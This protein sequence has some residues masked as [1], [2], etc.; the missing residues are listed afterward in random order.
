MQL[1][2]RSDSHSRID[3]KR[4]AAWSGVF[5]L[6]VGV[7]AMMLL[8]RES[9]LTRP[10][11][12]PVEVPIFDLTDPP[13]LPL[14]PP[15]IEIPPPPINLQRMITPPTVAPLPA[16]QPITTTMERVSSEPDEWPPLTPSTVESGSGADPVAGTGLLLTLKRISGRDPAY[17]R[18]ELARGIEGE[19]LLRV[20]VNPA[21]A[22]QTIEVIGGSGNRHLEL[23]AIRAVKGWRFQP[24][25]VNGAPQ[26]AWAQ[27]P[28]VFHLD[29]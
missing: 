12:L 5:L 9:T 17:P 29:R 10:R 1:T 11:M 19:V 14:P 4:V 23:A 8:P 25:S 3:P 27:V 13:P 16:T 6:H 15:P 28:F 26:S 21:G 7:L 24:H 18:R 2:S 20:L 22:A